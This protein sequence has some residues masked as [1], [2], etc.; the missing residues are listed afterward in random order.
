MILFGLPFIDLSDWSK[1]TVYKECD[2]ENK[3]I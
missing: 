1:Y 3:V 2:A